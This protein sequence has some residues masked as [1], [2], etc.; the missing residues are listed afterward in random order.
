MRKTRLYLLM[1][2]LFTA[3]TVV[4][5]QAKDLPEFMIFTYNVDLTE[6]N[7]KILADAGFNIVYGPV[8]KIDLN[9]GFFI[10]LLYKYTE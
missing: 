3:I 5:P 2:F 9:R 6:K 8:D 1:C 7:V 4:S 10:L